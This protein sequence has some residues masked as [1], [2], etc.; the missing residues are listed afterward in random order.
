MSKQAG[1]LDLTFK[2]STTLLAKQYYIMKM[3]GSSTPEGVTLASAHTD[4]QIGVLQ[5]EPVE[6]GAEAVVRIIGTSKVI[7]GT[8][9]AIGD[10]ITAD[11]SGKADVAD[12]DKHWVIGI[13]LET[14]A[15]DGDLIE[16]L[17]VHFKASI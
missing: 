17:L 1:V 10:F 12:T 4:V 7:I 14:G 15:A 3:S 16:M 9:I 6:Q 5:N 13:A 8:P 11:A 2:A